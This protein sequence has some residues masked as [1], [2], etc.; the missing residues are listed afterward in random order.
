MLSNIMLRV[1]KQSVIIMTF[2]MRGVIMQDCHDEYH[3]DAY[4]LIV[5]NVRKLG[6]V[7]LSVVILSNIMLYCRMLLWSVNIMTF[8]MTSGVMH[9]FH[10]ECHYTE[11]YYN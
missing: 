10:D 9:C 6:V 8:A 5:L 4:N 2:L 11:Y 3:N 7:M 1:I